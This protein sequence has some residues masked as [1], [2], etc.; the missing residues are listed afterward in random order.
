MLKEHLKVLELTMWIPRYLISLIHGIIWPDKLTTLA[1]ETSWR[2]PIRKQDDFLKLM[3]YNIIIIIVLLT[4]YHYIITLGPIFDWKFFPSL[5]PFPGT[6]GWP[7]DNL[8]VGTFW[9]ILRPRTCWNKAAWRYATQW[10][11]YTFI[12]LSVHR[13]GQ[14]KQ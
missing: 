3:Q 10:P 1:H 5:R 13:L 12:N 14:D 8:S 9:V 6:G 11:D 4:I 7:K 2:G